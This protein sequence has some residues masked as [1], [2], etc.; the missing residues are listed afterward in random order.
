MSNRRTYRLLRL[1]RPRRSDDDGLP[2]LRVGLSGTRLGR[3]AWRNLLLGRSL[4]RG[5]HVASLVDRRGGLVAAFRPNLE[6]EPRQG[7][8]QLFTAKAVKEICDRLG[9]D[10]VIRG[11]QAP[12]H[13]YAFFAECHLLTIFSA[14]GYKGITASDVNMGASLEINADM[15]LTIRQLKVSEQFRQKRVNDAERL[16]KLMKA[17][18]AAA[19]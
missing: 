18:Q 9:V 19:A 15:R 13:G 11:H 3:R 17:K 7:I 2:A 4:S 5:L 14:P 10:L 12:L 16:K 6:R 1:S 8:G